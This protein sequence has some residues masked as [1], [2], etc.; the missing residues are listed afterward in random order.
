[1]QYGKRLGR[2]K[3]LL[4]LKPINSHRFRAI[5]Q[6]AAVEMKRAAVERPPFDH[7]NE[8]FA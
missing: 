3:S 6:F 1:M 2:G 4:C 5:S 7:S 8:P